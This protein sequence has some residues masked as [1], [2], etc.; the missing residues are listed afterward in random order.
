M[1]IVHP[2]VRYLIVCEDVVTSEQETRNVTIVNLVSTIQPTAG[3]QYPL[4]REEM[5]V[6]LQLAECRGPAN[7]WVEI[8]FADTEAI[9]F[10][11]KDRTIP[12]PTD[13]LE[14]CGLTFRIRNCVSS[15]PG[16]YCVRFVYN[17]EI[18]A[19]NPLLLR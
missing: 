1:S 15:Q 18:I 17:E 2:T 14:V 13:P 16:L 6:F 12:F 9:V 11:T 3:Q 19:E 8:A 5:C 7:G 10:R 4:R